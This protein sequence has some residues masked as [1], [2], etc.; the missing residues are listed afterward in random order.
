MSEIADV[1]PTIGPS[2][3]NDSKVQAAH[4]I[5]TGLGAIPQG[6]IWYPQLEQG[7]AGDTGLAVG[8]QI[9]FQGPS[10]DSADPSLG[11]ALGLLKKMLSC[12]TVARPVSG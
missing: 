2:T 9:P 10:P 8:R 12:R 3:F 4:L 6:G 5:R 1:T 11:N 7:V